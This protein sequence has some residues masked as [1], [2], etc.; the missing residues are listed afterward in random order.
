MPLKMTYWCK[1]T[2]M[3][4]RD[5]NSFADDVE[6]TFQIIPDA[7]MLEPETG[8][9]GDEC[10]TKENVEDMFTTARNVRVTTNGRISKYR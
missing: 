10:E 9:T 6:K 2:V 7:S 8:K 1:K 5:C 3:T 4:V